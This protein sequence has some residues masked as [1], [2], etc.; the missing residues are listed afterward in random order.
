MDTYLTS[1]MQWW[2]EQG[3]DAYPNNIKKL[4]RRL[5]HTNYIESVRSLL[6][7]R[8][9]VH[10]CAIAHVRVSMYVRACACA[11]ACVQLCVLPCGRQHARLVPVKTQWQD[12]WQ[13]VETKR[14]LY[15]CF[16]FPNDF[17]TANLTIAAGR[18]RFVPP[19]STA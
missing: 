17:P 2:C 3:W 5:D 14:S 15:F 6:C 1:I 13:C 9:C 4:T 10:V 19:C 11:C 18:I 7:V 12:A 16:F 8:G